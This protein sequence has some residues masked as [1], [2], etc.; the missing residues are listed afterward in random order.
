VRGRN[1]LDPAS[2]EIGDWS[3]IDRGPAGD[4]RGSSANAL[5]SEFLGDYNFA[6][7][8]NAFAVAVWNDG[9]DASDCPAEDAYR[10]SLVDGTPGAR[11]AVQ[12]DCPATFGNTD[13]YG[14]SYPDPT[15]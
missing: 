1:D 15:P 7:A 9:R 6:F 2:G 11:P 10:Q 8:T 13:I 3:E 5:D 14:G 12:Q 4:A